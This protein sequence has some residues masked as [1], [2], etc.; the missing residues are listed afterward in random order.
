[1]LPMRLP[2]VFLL[3]AVAWSASL[4]AGPIQAPTERGHLGIPL[5]EFSSTTIGALKQ[6][7]PPNWSQGNPVDLIGDA[8]AARFRAALDACLADPGVDG[9]LVILAPQ[10]MTAPLE[11][12][13]VVVEC[14]RTSDK[15]LLTCDVW[16]HAYYIDYRNARPKYLENFWALANW[17]FAAKNF[18]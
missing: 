15:P 10:A 3:A 7:L 9:A 17:D 4:T 1:M 16:E 5:A 6:A 2:A 14:A 13:R 11:A 18:A 8:D 12:A